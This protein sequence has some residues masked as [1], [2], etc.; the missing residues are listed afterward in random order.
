MAAVCFFRISVVFSLFFFLN[1]LYHGFSEFPNFDPCQ[2]PIDAVL[3]YRNPPHMGREAN[4]LNGIDQLR[5]TLNVRQKKYLLDQLY[6]LRFRVEY[7]LVTHLSNP[8]LNG[9][10]SLLAQ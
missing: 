10:E 4:S 6:T 3:T 8:F 5:G 2:I 7:S 9:N 1:I